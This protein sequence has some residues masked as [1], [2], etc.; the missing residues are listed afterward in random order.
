MEELRPQK[1]RR[2][3]AL[4]G[5]EES[6][7]LENQ[8]PSSRFK[9]PEQV[10][11]IEE[12]QKSVEAAASA[13][14][15]YI[16]SSEA[17]TSEE[18]HTIID[19]VLE[20]M[21]CESPEGHIVASGLQSAAPHE[22]GTGPL[23]KNE[24]IVIDIYPRSKTS[25][26]FADMTRT[27]CRGTPSKE[28]QKMYDAVLGAQ[29]L[30]ISMVKPGA[31]CRD[32]QESVEKFFIDA[33]FVTHGD[34]KEKHGFSYLEGFVHSLGHG[35][36][37]NIHEVPR[38]GR[39]S[40]DI[41]MEGDVITIEPGLYYEAIGGVRIEDMLLVTKDGYRNLTNFSKEFVLHE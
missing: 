17:P 20:R 39:K 32:I 24:P 4:D 11:A 33:G 30:A 16:R 27:V 35:V 10:V 14:V 28:V 21:G 18:A 23:K 25:G 8:I 9:T 15:E 38:I 34:G 3:P 26:Y 22:A 13:V 19:A 12:A 2:A 29:E 6:V 1:H 36:G 31:V 7:M 5:A 37:C 41:L 40:D